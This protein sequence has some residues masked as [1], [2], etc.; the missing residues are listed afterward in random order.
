LAKQ[1]KSHRGEPTKKPYDENTRQLAR[2]QKTV[3]DE[4]KV[5][6]E[7]VGIDITRHLENHKA[8]RKLGL[9]T[10]LVYMSFYFNLVW[11]WCTIS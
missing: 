11:F 8:L 3:E 4:F 1:Y 7:R 10:C 2:R 9:I 5:I 6:H